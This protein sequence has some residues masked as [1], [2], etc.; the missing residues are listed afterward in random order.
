MRRVAILA[1]ALLAFAAGWMLR[2]CSG[3]SGPRPEAPPRA[4]D[5]TS[6]TPS[7]SRAHPTKRGDGASPRHGDDERRGVT[8][9]PDTAK[10]PQSPPRPDPQR[11]GEAKSGD[12]P[13]PKSVAGIVVD[14]KSGEPVAGANIHLC[15]YGDDGDLGWS[16]FSTD[17][18]GRFSAKAL[19]DWSSDVRRLEV[20]AGR[21]GYR[22]ARVPVMTTEVR[23]E[24]EKLDRPPLPGRIVGTAFGEDGK[25]LTGRLLVHVCDDLDMHSSKTWTLADASGRFAIVGVGPGHWTMGLAESEESSEVNVTEEQDSPVELRARFDGPHPGAFAEG[26]LDEVTFLHRLAALHGYEQQQLELQWLRQG[27]GRDL[28]VTG[29]PS[30][31]GAYV[32]LERREGARC[33]WRAQIE[34]GRAKFPSIPFS[35]WRAVL[36]RPGEPDI[37]AD[38]DLKAGD[39]AFEVALTPSK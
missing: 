2:G 23:V 38:V 33:E 11:G 17:D 25:P 26:T 37:A 22:S 4:P 34:E 13:L 28:V 8:P 6:G 10:I 35:K 16:G 19:P 12:T 24:M 31:A 21:D 30:V 9:S 32:R 20:I 15:A 5:S 36:V 18:E 3:T 14:S 1:V 27:P 29:L 39:G 7:V